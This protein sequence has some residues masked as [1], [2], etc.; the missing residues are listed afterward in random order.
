MATK[1]QWVQVGRRK[2]E[3]SN[4]EKVLYPGD[5]ILKAEVIAYY[6]DI[7]PTILYHIKGRPLTLIRFPDGI[8]SERFYQKNRPRWAPDW[9]EFK[10]LGEEK[11]DYILATEQATLLWLANLAALELHQMH[12]RQPHFDKP[13]YMVF[14]LDPPEERPFTDV[15][16][17]AYDL[18]EHIDTYGYHSF[19][20]TT[21]GKGLHIVVPVQPKWDFSTV[22]EA[23]KD[24]AQPFVTRNSQTVTLQIKKAARKGRILVDIYRNRNGQSIVSP[25]SLRGRLEAPV[26]MPLRWNELSELESSA[27]FTLQNVVE[28]VKAEGDAWEGI[29]GYAVDLH[30]H[31]TTDTEPQ[32]LAPSGRHKTPEQLEEYSKKRNFGLTTEPIALES[33]EEGNNFVI[34]RHHASRLHYDLRLEQD[35]VLK[36]WAVPKGMPPRPGVKRLAIETEDHP[37]EYL[38]FEG[39]IP[40]G[41][42]GGGEMWVYAL[43]KYQVTKQKGDGMYFRLDSPALSGEYRMHRMKGKEWLLEKVE[44]PQIDWLNDYIE[45][46]QA[47]IGNDPPEG[48]YVYEIKWDGIRAL[49][50]LEDGQVCIRTRNQNDV[51]RQFPELHQASGGLRATCGLFDGEIVCLDHQGRPEFKKVINR[52]QSSAEATIQQLSA[53]Q[54]VHCYLFDC[55]YLDGR[56]IINEPLE[57]RYEWL[58]DVVKKGTPYRLSEFF[59]DGQALFDAAKEHNLEGIMAKQKG[60]PYL[61]GRRS[62]YWLKIKVRQTADCLVI[63]YTKGKGDRHNYFGAL[64]LAQYSNGELKY[65]GKVGTGFNQ[66]TMAEINKMLEKLETI[67]KPIANKILGEKD[68]VWIDP[69][70]VVEVSYAR[71]TPDNIF[72]EAVFLRLR[73]DRYG[74]SL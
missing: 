41:E 44:S 29:G 45:P 35:G 49:F 55:L 58:K 59:D 16:D 13:D 22:F 39:T 63:G 57:R 11:K 73:P 7:A 50:A 70:M 5:G 38:T 18:K 46:M 53:T 71:L 40:K 67:P 30:T 9:V 33:I 20:K 47:E 64:H 2:L 21:G 74:E 6:H 68:T 28:K 48:N 62:N 56:V 10:T 32:K 69:K 25:Y 72:R 42:Y 8:E 65:R 27:Q 66:K 1:S 12:C 14:D 3:L 31:R 36:S 52:L 15:V 51:T 34:H 4:L 19:V 17:V 37:Y 54:P 61:P 43:G 60:S 26:S 23:A 24:L